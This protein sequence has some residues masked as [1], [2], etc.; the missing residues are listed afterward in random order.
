MIDWLTGRIATH[1]TDAHTNRTTIETLMG[2]YESARQRKPVTFP[3]ASGP[4][5]LREMIADGS[6]PVR[7]PGAYDIRLQQG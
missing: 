1:P 2:L 4:S 7:V 5:P 3:L 6:L